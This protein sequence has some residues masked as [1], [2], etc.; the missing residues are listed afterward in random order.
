MGF[1][2][3]AG[4]RKGYFQAESPFYCERLTLPPLSDS[5]PRELLFVKFHC[6]AE[7]SAWLVI[8]PTH[9]DTPSLQ[10]QVIH[11]YGWTN[12]SRSWDCMWGDSTLQTIGRPRPR[13]AII[14]FPIQ[15]GPEKFRSLVIM[16]YCLGFV[17]PRTVLATSK[18]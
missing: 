16:S 3:I 15:S 9:P 1:I 11:D 5:M 10:V 17:L 4:I 6:D 14:C 18:D 7:G 13:S 8:S 2:D 12:A